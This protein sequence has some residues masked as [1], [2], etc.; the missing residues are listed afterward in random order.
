MLHT[1]PAV[2]QPTAGLGLMFPI[3]CH[4]CS[5][6]PSPD[7]R[8]A[9][10]FAVFFWKVSANFWNTSGEMLWP[11]RFISVIV[12]KPSASKGVNAY[13][14]DQPGGNFL[15]ISQPLVLGIKT[16]TEIEELAS[17]M[18]MLAALL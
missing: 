2:L 11:W 7:P 6:A 18:L 13:L 8:R 10:A 15:G 9:C 14:G 3:A 1:E 4:G 17:S 12:L 5:P 16:K